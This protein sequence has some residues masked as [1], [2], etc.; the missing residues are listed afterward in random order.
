[1]TDVAVAERWAR[2]VFEL[3]TETGQLKPLTDQLSRFAQTYAANPELRSVLDNPVVDERHRTEILSAIAQ[4]LGLAPHAVNTVKL[5]AQRARLHALPDIAR[6]LTQLADERAGVVRAQ[7]VSAA[8]LGEAYV[9]RLAAELEKVAGKKVVI[10]RSVDPALLGG[11]VARVG[12][13][14]IDGSLRSRLD[15]LERQLTESRAG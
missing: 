9:T 14:V 15:R 10:E 4:R 13:H 6:R 7:V 2:A 3:G 8:P 5:L 12:D 11:L 1:M